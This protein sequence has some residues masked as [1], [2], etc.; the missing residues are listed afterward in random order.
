MAAAPRTGSALVAT[1]KRALLPHEHSLGG[2]ALAIIPKRSEQPQRDIKAVARAL[3]ARHWGNRWFQVQRYVL[4]QQIVPETARFF[5]LTITVNGILQPA[6]LA[7]PVRPL[8]WSIAQRIANPDHERS[9]V[10]VNAYPDGSR[11][12]LYVRS[13]DPIHPYIATIVALT[14]PVLPGLDPPPADYRERLWTAIALLQPAESLD[15]LLDTLPLFGASFLHGDETFRLYRDPT[16]KVRHFYDRAEVGYEYLVD[17][18]QWDGRVSAGPIHGGK[19]GDR[20]RF[21]ATVQ[22][23][24]QQLRK[25]G[26]P[27]T[28][29]NVAQRMPGRKQPLSERHFSRLV[30]N[31]HHIGWSQIVGKRT[32]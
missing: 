12:P 13:A 1:A 3:L 6:P 10:G 5:P 21:L 7:D 4:Q 29:G 16:P 22:S 26:L 32:P 9:L 19:H 23:I 24:A 28:Q 8:I 30:N 20:E 2:V 11:K 15:E 25:D 14:S 17:S 31:H 18:R 27:V